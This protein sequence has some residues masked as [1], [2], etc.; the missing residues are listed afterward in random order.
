MLIDVENNGEGNWKGA[1]KGDRLVIRLRVII[2]YE[3]F[4]QIKM[5][6]LSC[7]LVGKS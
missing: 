4:V 1:E 3:I 2:C 5:I 6:G 7:D